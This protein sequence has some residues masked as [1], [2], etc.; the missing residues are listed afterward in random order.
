MAAA[1][2]TRNNLPD[3]HT[4]NPGVQM[5]GFLFGVISRQ[6]TDIDAV[7]IRCGFTLLLL[8]AKLWKTQGDLQGIA[9]EKPVPT[10]KMSSQLVFW[11]ALVVVMSIVAFVIYKSKEGR[12]VPPAATEQADGMPAKKMAGVMQ[13]VPRTTTPMDDYTRYFKSDVYPAR[14]EKLSFGILYHWFL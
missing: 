10:Q 9:V 2:S 3:L 7:G 1:S 4:E 6:N 13:T 11:G 8:L 5:P 14:S 12:P